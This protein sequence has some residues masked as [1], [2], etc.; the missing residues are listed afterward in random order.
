MKISLYSSTTE[1]LTELGSR[2]KSVRVDMSITQAELAEMTNLSCRT[3]SNLETGR[4]VS[5]ATLIDVMRA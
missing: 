3:I 2:I 5:L 4:D 1:I